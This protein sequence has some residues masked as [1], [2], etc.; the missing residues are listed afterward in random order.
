MKSTTFLAALLPALATAVPNVTVVPLSTT[1][2]SSWPY[3]LGSQGPGVDMT[4]YLR[5]V[6]SDADDTAV[7]DLPMGTTNLNFASGKNW[8]SVTANLRKSRSFAQGYWRCFNGVMSYLNGGAGSDVT[9]A[10][11]VRNAWMAVGASPTGY[12][13]QPY[14][15]YIDGVRQSGV[16]LGA[17]NKTTW[18]FAYVR[19]D[20][21][22]D[23][24]ETK[25]QGLPVDP[26][27][28]P[29]AG[30]NPEFFGFVKAEIF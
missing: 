10:K 26:D 13:L 11:D 28:E 18:G 21:A 9:V 24:Y 7:N 17:L 25:L 22:L 12:P 29:T 3:F 1:D 30:R 16:Y 20:C 2:C 5:F 14:A 19:P 27:T 8:T 23:Y 6:V 4:G 15:H